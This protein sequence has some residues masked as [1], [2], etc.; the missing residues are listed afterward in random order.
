M[1]RPRGSR[2]EREKAKRLA[3]GGGKLI[4]YIRVST[5]NQGT[6]GHSLD[7]QRD[8]LTKASELAGFELVEIVEDVESGAKRRDAFEDAWAR[9]LAGE[10]EGLAFAKLDRV[11]R[12]LAHLGAIIEDAEREGL[13]LFASDEGLHIYRGEVKNPAVDIL[14]GVAK[15]ERRR[16][17]E[18]TKEGLAAAKAKGVRL[19]RAPENIGELSERAT[20]MR[21]NV[22]PAT[23]KHWTLQQIA[24][25][26]NAEGLQTA[27]GATF[28]PTVVARM[29]FRVDPTA[30][31][32]GGYGLKAAVDTL[33]QVLEAQLQVERM[34]G[35]SRRRVKRAGGEENTEWTK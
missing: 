10:A 23:G 1:A 29:I 3:N 7:G 32:E 33:G 18:R 25:A 30:N 22:N 17:S 24:D 15:M 27:R 20:Q 14:A 13:T 5:E 6:N 11:G 8:R 26:F 28:S 19:G 12:S 16:I 34:M 2:R 21:R 4:G 35:N 9:V 31:P